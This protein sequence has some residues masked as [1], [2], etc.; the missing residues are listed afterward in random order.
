MKYSQHSVP[1]LMKLSGLYII[2][3]YCSNCFKL[4][5]FSLALGSFRLE[6]RLKY[7]LSWLKAFVAFSVRPGKCYVAPPIMPQSLLSYPLQFITYQSSYHFMLQ[8]IWDTETVVNGLCWR[9]FG[10][11]GCHCSQRQIDTEDE[12]S[13]YLQTS[14][15]QCKYQRAATVPRVNHNKI[16]KSEITC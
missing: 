14:A 2:G 16:L 11:T 15:T 5:H 10:S 13:V 6:S 9:Y 1:S 8:G 12:G 4:Q 7:L 3:N